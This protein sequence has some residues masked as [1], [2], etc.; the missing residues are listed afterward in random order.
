LANVYHQIQNW[1]IVA[2]GSNGNEPIH[3]NF[4]LQHVNYY[5]VI[6]NENIRYIWWYHPPSTVSF[7]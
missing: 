5:N 2:D 4:E 1:Q 7:L 6:E 3:C